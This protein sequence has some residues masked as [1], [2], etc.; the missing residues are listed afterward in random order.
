VSGLDLAKAKSYFNLNSDICYLNHASHGPLPM[1]ARKAYDDFLDSW[2]KSEHE[3]DVESFRIIKELRGKLARM[4]GAPAERIGLSSNTTGGFNVITGGYPWRKG[5]NVVLSHG[6]FPAG[7][8]PW[9]SLKRVG[10]ELKFARDENGFINEDALITLVDDN[11]RVISVSWVQFSNGYR[12][13]I[14]K[15]GEFCRSKNILFCVDGVQGTGVIP[16]DVP[17]NHI[18]LFTSGCAKWMCGPCGTGFFYLSEKA[19]KILGPVNIGWLSVDWN[20]DF[21]DLI[22]YDL[23]ERKGPSKYESGTYAYQDI[24]ALNASVDMHLSFDRKEVW[25]HI[26]KLTGMLVEKI[27]SDER[28]SLV[29]SREDSRRSGIVTF[30]APDSNSLYKY[31]RENKFIICVREGGIRVSP[32]FYNTPEAMESF[33]GA[34]DNFR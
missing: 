6:E 2:Q 34:L 16:I 15:L 9:V 21:T 23:P 20:D 14:K 31:L 33:I 17:G 28:F 27:E 32:H 22:K 5:D 26:R 7:V 30:R 3:H 8:Y 10:V 18:D 13:D 1:T 25:E 24:R 11:T 19:E 4:I 29:S 12:A